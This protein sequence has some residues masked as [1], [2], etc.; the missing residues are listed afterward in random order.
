MKL[1]KREPAQPMG[2]YIGL[3]DASGTKSVAMEVYSRVD[4]EL[5][6]RCKG[7]YTNAAGETYEEPSVYTEKASLNDVIEALHVS[8]QECA[9]VVDTLGYYHLLYANGSTELLGTGYW[10]T[11]KQSDN[12]TYINGMYLNIR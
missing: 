4:P 9:L 8:K 7:V 1:F 3:R 2:F 10:T 5:C 6:T 11:T 12:T